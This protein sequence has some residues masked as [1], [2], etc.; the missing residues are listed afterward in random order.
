M[1]I[2]TKT[3]WILERLSR[4][5]LAIPGVSL[6][7]GEGERKAM[8]GGPNY[9]LPAKDFKRFPADG[10]RIGLYTHGDSG[11]DVIREFEVCLAMNQSMAGRLAEAGARKIRVIRPG[12]PW[13]QE[14]VTF[15]VVG[16]VYNDGRKGE[17]FVANAI[18]AG[19]SFVACSTPKKIR[20][21]SRGIWPCP[22]THSAESEDSRRA[23][24]QSID[25]LVVTS[26][27]EGG[28]MPVLEAI[29]SGVPVI[30]PDVGWCWEFPVIRYV[31]GDWESLKSVLMAL[32]HPPSWSEW[33]ESH[34]KLFADL[35]KG[36]IAA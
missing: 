35:E 12:A 1:N 4:E 9:Y 29:A 20:A 28:P 13:K 33:V 19:F 18:A 26:L 25:Y 11:F 31:R 3:G 24:Y 16:R 15:G 14:R 8:K 27:D 6:N 23:F 30:A 10:W 5:L 17:G 7:C 21:T 34:R 22:V 32:T 2:V 36:R